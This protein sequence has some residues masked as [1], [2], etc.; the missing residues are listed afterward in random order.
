MTTCTPGGLLWRANVTE[1]NERIRRGMGWY[2]S[3]ECHDVLDRPL[4]DCWHSASPPSKANVCPVLDYEHSLDALLEPLGV[5]RERGWTWLVESM[6]GTVY[7]ACITEW[8]PPMNVMTGTGHG[9][10]RDIYADSPTPSEA[11]ALAVAE[12]L[13]ASK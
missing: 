10:K 11:L 2:V 8:E 13:E 7:R 4:P 1:T 3:E 5:L 12:A 9:I 6:D